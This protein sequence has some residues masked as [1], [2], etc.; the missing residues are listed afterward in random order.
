MGSETYHELRIAGTWDPSTDVASQC[1]EDCFTFLTPEA[2]R[3]EVNLPLPA[4]GDLKTDPA[5]GDGISLVSDV[6]KGR[7]SR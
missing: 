4:T 5:P 6:G 7:C 1:H 3:P 2:S